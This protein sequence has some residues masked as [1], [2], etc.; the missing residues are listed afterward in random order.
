MGEIQGQNQ[1]EIK[2]ATREHQVEHKEHKEDKNEIQEQSQEE[3]KHVY[4]EEKNHSQNETEQAKGEHQVEHKENMNEMQEQNQEEIKQAIREHRVEHKEHKEDK[5]E[6]QEQSQEGIKHESEEEKNQ[7]HNETEQAKGEHQVEHKENMNEMQ[8]QNQEEIKQE[9]EE[10]KNQSHNETEQESEVEKNK[11]HNETEQESEG[12]VEEEKNQ[13]HNEIHQ[14]DNDT[15]HSSDFERSTYENCQDASFD[16]SDSEEDATAGDMST[17]ESIQGYGD[18]KPQ[19]K[20]SRWKKMKGFLSKPFKSSKTKHDIPNVDTPL[21]SKQWCK[22]QIFQRPMCL[23]STNEEGNVS[24]EENALNQIKKIDCP[25]VVVAIAGLYR[26]GKSYLMNR[27]AGSNAGMYMYVILV[28]ENY[29]DD[30]QHRD[31]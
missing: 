13:G 5:N 24:V 25:L 22:L 2:Q 15:Y 27:L 1:E 18:A 28:N 29:L 11:S 16:Y 20:G 7:S 10:E 23:I 30:I 9:S 8:E 4:E 12:R 14:G 17:S 19:K 3:I 6:I 26:T 21:S 31:P